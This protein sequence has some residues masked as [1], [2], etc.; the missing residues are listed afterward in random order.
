M[1]NDYDQVHRLRN[2]RAGWEA[3]AAGGLTM[4]AIAQCALQ[5]GS[6]LH[7]ILLLLLGTTNWDLSPQYLAGGAGHKVRRWASGHR[8]QGAHRPHSSARVCS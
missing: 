6:P 3:V 7:V 2:A 5:S 8:T 4:A 1:G